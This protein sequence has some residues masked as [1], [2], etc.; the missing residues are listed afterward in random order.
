MA[1]ATASSQ[2]TDA[3]GANDP[4]AVEVHEADFPEATDTSTGPG[5]GQIDVL[6]D[7]S[8]AITVRLGEV[9]M[10]VRDLLQLN[11]GQ[12]ITLNRRVGEPA[13][14]YLR[15]VQFA[16]GDLVI[17]GDRLGVRIREILQVRQSD[18]GAQ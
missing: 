9:E 7:A 17:V 3:A 18:A 15:G 1:E 10:P 12:V 5:P 4:A 16:T 13:A 2:P 11:Q 8:L 6:L 14:L